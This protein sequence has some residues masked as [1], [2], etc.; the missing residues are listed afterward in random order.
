MTTRSARVGCS[1][2]LL[3]GCQPAVATNPPDAS[4]TADVDRVSTEPALTPAPADPNEVLSNTEAAVV[5]GDRTVRFSVQATGAVEAKVQ[6]L[7]IVRDQEASLQANGSFAGQPFEVSLR[8]DAQRMRGGAE[9]GP[10]FDVATGSHL[11]D[12]LM[13]GLV[14]MGILH[15]VAIILGGRPPDRADGGVREWVRADS[16]RLEVGE[17]M[18]RPDEI[19]TD[20]VVSFELVVADQPSGTASVWFDE[21]SGLP[22]ARQQIVTFPEGQMQV[23]ERYEWDL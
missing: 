18:T 2:L 19:S 9:G 21:R 12:A 7:L 17:G 5:E 11:R 1:V 20:H 16:A 22:V 13:I 3:A 4:S 15:N 10:Q 8:A 6:G 14:R 23:R